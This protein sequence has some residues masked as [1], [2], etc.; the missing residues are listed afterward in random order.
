MRDQSFYGSN[1]IEKYPNRK[2]RMCKDCITMHVDNWDPNS[3]LWILQEID[4]PWVQEEW[5][6]LLATFGKEPEKLNGTS[7][8]GRYLS[9]MKL[10]QFKD[11]RWKDND[12]LQELQDN[13]V[14]QAMQ[15]QGYSAA[16]IDNAIAKG[17]IGVPERPEM[18]KFEEKELEYA[19][20]DYFE[21]QQNIENG[22]V[23][24][25]TEDDKR[26]LCIKW[27]KAYRPEE[28]I[29]LEQLFQEMMA[30]YDIFA[31]GDINTL[32][33]ACK[34]SLKANQLLDI[35]DIE[36]AQKATKMY[37]SLMKSGKWTAA[38]IKEEE[39]E[40]VDSISELLVICERE[41]FI[42]RYHASGP[43]DHVDR[44]IEDLQKYT[45]DL[46][47]NETGLETMFENALKQIEE[48]QQRIKEAA[49]A[50][51]EAEEDKLFDYDADVDSLDD[52]DFFDYQEMLDELGEKDKQFYST[53]LEE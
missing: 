38:Q 23:A 33:L 11:Y 32:K 9:K 10:K 7:I 5:N 2:L 36:G 1:N 29:I 49:E 15:R 35:G 40:G 46:V 30:S 53:F 28:W 18:P 31:A 39:S 48:E 19:D 50:G 42:P 17:S 27:G 3:F 51:E 22:M 25:L 14:R 34:C 20:E 24:E 8:L 41:G 47:S 12:L 37:D 52:Q 43:Q 21:I 45:H 4:V 26:G 13:K 16:E 6:K 44:V